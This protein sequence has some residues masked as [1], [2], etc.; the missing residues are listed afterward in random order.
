MKPRLQL[1]MRLRSKLLQGSKNMK[2]H[3]SKL[4]Q[5][6]DFFIPLVVRG[7]NHPIN[8]ILATNYL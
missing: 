4:F 8:P 5:I 1:P 3:R 6:V 7:M 2:R